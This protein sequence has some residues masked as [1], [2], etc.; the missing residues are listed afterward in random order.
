MDNRAP[1]ASDV[2]QVFHQG[3]LMAQQRAGVRE[4]MERIGNVVLRDYMPEQHRDFFTLLP[5]LFIGSS[6][7]AGQVW[8]S[9]LSNSPGF[10]HTPDATTLR[11]DARLLPDDPLAAVL[12]TGLQLGCLG[13]QFETRRRNRANGIV[14]T[15]DDQGFTVEVRQSFGN[16]AKYIQTRE[17]H[18][19]SS[20]DQPG[21]MTHGVGSLPPPALDLITHCDTFLIASAVTQTQAGVAAGADISH[22]GGKPGFVRVDAHG[23]LTWPDFQGNYFSIRLATCWSMPGAGSFLSTSNPATCCS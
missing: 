15:V 13:L 2:R 21:A 18:T 1:M 23:A 12:G 5:T 9:M 17:L 4:K 22:R 20:P 3:E 14:T 11:V 7:E 6:D 19:E 10:V 8:A 16:C